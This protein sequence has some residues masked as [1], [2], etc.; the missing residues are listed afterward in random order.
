MGFDSDKTVG[1][2]SRRAELTRL[3]AT[4]EMI[5]APHFPYPGVGTVAAKGDGFVWVPAKP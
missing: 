5:F 2:A 4:H 3:A 1:K